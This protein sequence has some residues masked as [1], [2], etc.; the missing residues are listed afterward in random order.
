[1]KHYRKVKIVAT[2]GPSS[3]SFEKIQ[4]FVQA[5]VNVFRLNMSHG[6]HEIHA[7]SIQWIRQAEESCGYPLGILVDLQGPKLRVGKFQSSEGVVLKEGQSFALDLDSTLGDETRVQFPHGNLYSYLK[8]ESLVLL[9]DGAIQLK[10]VKQSATSLET[11]VIVG[12]V[13]SNHKGVNIPGCQLPISA[14]TEKDRTDLAFALKHPIDFIALSFVQKPE[15]LKELRALVQN[16]VSILAKIEKPQALDCLE[17][18]ITLS[19]GVMVARGDLGVELSPEKVPSLQKKIVR[20]SKALGKPVIVATQMLE[21]M[22]NHPFPT[23]AEASD[24]ATA[25]YDGADAVMLSAESAAGAYPIEAIHMMEKIISSVE[26]DDLYLSMLKQLGGISTPTVSDA[27]SA[28][29]AQLS[30]TLSASAIVTYTATG[31]TAQRVAHKRPPCL[32]FGMTD[33]L[34]TARQLCL[35]WGVYP[36]LIQGVKTFDDMAKNSLEVVQKYGGQKGDHFILTCGIPF[37]NPGS[38]NII[39][40][41]K[42][43]G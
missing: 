24:V 2:L 9:N 31:G 26:R 25:V 42:L 3:A 28:A 15:D 34:R 14:L 39:N 22:I 5:G 1:M 13:L 27:I 17:E 35:V 41:Q 21:T 7:Q 12:G 32:I 20:L 19:D 16:K 38:T 36:A 37:G 4:T 33:S 43:L 18:I 6:T 10:V 23:R 11:K 8:E 29:A 30:Y 40:V